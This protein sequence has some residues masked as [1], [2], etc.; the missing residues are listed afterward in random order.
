MSKT[1]SRS[2]TVMAREVESREPP[3][4]QSV[5][6]KSTAVTGHGGGS[7]ELS[8]QVRRTRRSQLFGELLRGHSRLKD[9]LVQTA[10]VWKLLERGGQGKKAKDGSLHFILSS[11]G[12]RSR[13]VACLIDSCPQWP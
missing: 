1:M 11:Q 12:R 8:E 6:S 4:L 2:D 3:E 9:K 13:G 10:W 5:N 7:R